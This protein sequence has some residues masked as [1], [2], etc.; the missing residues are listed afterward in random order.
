MSSYPC[1]SKHLSFDGLPKVD[2][3]NAQ[4]SDL[5]LRPILSYM[6]KYNYQIFEFF[7]NLFVTFTLLSLEFF[8]NLFVTFIPLSPLSL[9][10]IIWFTF[11]K[12]RKKSKCY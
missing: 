5:S 3:L 8:T 6:G 10:K 2:K 11:C 1:G 9:A 7:T 12:E 4:R